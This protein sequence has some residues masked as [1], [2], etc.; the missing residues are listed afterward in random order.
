LLVKFYGATVDNKGRE[1]LALF[2]KEDN[3]YKKTVIICSESNIYGNFYPTIENSNGNTILE[4]NYSVF[5]GLTHHLSKNEINLTLKELMLQR[6]KE[7]KLVFKNGNFQ[8]YPLHELITIDSIK[9]VIGTSRLTNNPITYYNINFV[10]TKVTS[11]K[12]CLKSNVGCFVND[13]FHKGEVIHNGSLHKTAILELKQYLA[14]GE[15]LNYKRSYKHC[16]IACGGVTVAITYYF[17][18]KSKRVS[19]WEGAPKVVNLILEVLDSKTEWELGK[20]I[21][22]EFNSFYGPNLYYLRIKD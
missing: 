7:E 11:Q 14:Y 21:L 18:G 3:Q 17:D 22:P 10:N 15:F 2:Y 16:H 1:L 8:L 20:E 13:K 19:F 5:I 4:L 9:V 6:Y 12:L